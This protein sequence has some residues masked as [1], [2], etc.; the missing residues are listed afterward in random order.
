MNV[1]SNS[2]PPRSTTSPALATIA[3]AILCAAGPAGATGNVARGQTLYKGCA[4]CHS[5][6]KN[7]VG[8]MHKGL[9]GRKA[10]SVPGYD[11]SAE[12]K[13]SGIVWT[14]ENLDKWLNDPTQMVPDTKMLFSVES[15]QDRA[16]LIAFLKLRAR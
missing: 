12:L 5:I 1:R 11:Y 6:D 3:I 14:E 15:P 2:V 10:G 7:D 16:D 13:S 9:V 4:D 8:P